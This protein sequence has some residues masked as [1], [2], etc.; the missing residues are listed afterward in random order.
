MRLILQKHQHRLFHIYVWEMDLI[1][2]FTNAGSKNTF[3][4]FAYLASSDPSG[5]EKRFWTWPIRPVF[6][7]SYNTK[8]QLFDTPVKKLTIVIDIIKGR[9]SSSH[10]RSD[11]WSTH[12]LI[13]LCLWIY[14]ILYARY[15]LRQFW[16]NANKK[17]LQMNKDAGKVSYPLLSRP[18]Q[19]SHW[20]LRWDGVIM[21][22][23]SGSF[24]GP[25]I[26]QA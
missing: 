14:Q 26:T 23:L 6:L 9:R 13:F 18:V 25:H 16:P 7:N 5:G 1:K 3:L 12:F 11:V 22:S 2:D 8:C 17:Y 15:W 4:S 21:S 19:S 24:S 10:R 20:T